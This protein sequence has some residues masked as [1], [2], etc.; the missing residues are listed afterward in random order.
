MKEKLIKYVIF[1]TKWGYFGLVATDNGLLR[2][3]LPAAERERV[4]SHLLKN[5]PAAQ[6][7]RDLFKDV[8]E[9]ITAYFEGDCINFSVPVVLDGFSLFARSVLTACKGIKFGQTVSYSRLAKIAGKPTAA[10]AVGRVLA[11]NPLPL[12]IPCHRIICANGSL[13][14]FSATAGVNLK[15]KMLKLEGFTEP[16]M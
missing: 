16:R 5:L 14:G 2:T 15:K 10:R 11:K 12:I 9:Q 8:Q 3:C 1:K 13:G 6:Y 4:E 7:D